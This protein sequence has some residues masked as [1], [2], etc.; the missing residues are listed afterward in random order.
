MIK[1]TSC[2]GSISEN[3]LLPHQSGFENEKVTQIGVRSFRLWRFVVVVVVVIATV[4][5]VY[6]LEFK[7]KLQ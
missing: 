7:F 5:A 3:R 6:L 1:S 4:K 2:I